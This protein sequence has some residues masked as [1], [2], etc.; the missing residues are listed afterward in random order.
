M[1]RHSLPSYRSALI[2]LKNWE[3]ATQI[4]LSWRKNGIIFQSFWCWTL[5]G[6]KRFSALWI[7]KT[8]LKDPRRQTHENRINSE[9]FGVDSFSSHTLHCWT[10]HQHDSNLC[11]CVCLE[12]FQVSK[13]QIKPGLWKYF[14]HSVS[15]P[16][17]PS[18]TRPHSAHLAWTTLKMNMKAS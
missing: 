12:S 5:K 8:C 17:F 9:C 13:H 1:F 2:W 18:F 15:S 6:E 10:C 14:S 7:H 16:S 11:V 4:L 3:F